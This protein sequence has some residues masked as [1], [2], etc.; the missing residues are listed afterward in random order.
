V[1]LARPP[2]RT[3]AFGAIDKTCGES[4]KGRSKPPLKT[5]KP[6]SYLGVLSE[7]LLVLEAEAFLAFLLCF[8]AC[9][10]SFLV[11]GAVV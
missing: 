2:D 7:V 9:F 1:T 4:K 5:P 8:L 3:G 6:A 11:V 10:F